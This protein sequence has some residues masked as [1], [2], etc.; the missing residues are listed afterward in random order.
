M[1]GIKLILVTLSPNCVFTVLGTKAVRIPERLCFTLCSVVIVVVCV[2]P[3]VLTC[4]LTSLT[5]PA[6][7]SF[8][9]FQTVPTFKS[10]TF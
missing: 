4:L 1:N 3:D 9:L 6:Q 5:E 2:L 7:V 10:K 8:Q